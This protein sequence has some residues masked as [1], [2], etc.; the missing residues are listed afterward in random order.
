MGNGRLIINASAGLEMGIRGRVCTA[1]CSVGLNLRWTGSWWL[2][3]LETYIQDTMDVGGNG[4][5]WFMSS[6][7]NQPI[8]L[9]LIC[10]S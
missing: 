6:F 2:L 7:P 4:A 9:I 5:F 8:S 10:A 1:F 3:L